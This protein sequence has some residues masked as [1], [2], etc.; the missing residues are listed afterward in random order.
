M[1]SSTDDV[2]L[3]FKSWGLFPF[4]E[5]EEIFKNDLDEYNICV[6]SPCYTK[7]LA[8]ALTLHGEKFE[9]FCKNEIIRTD[10]AYYLDAQLWSDVE[11]DWYNFQH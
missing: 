4:D 1:I 8:E 10:N 2:I 7:L 3:F 9:Q 5:E 6:N 11:Q